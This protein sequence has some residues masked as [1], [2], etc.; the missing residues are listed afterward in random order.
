MVQDRTRHGP[1]RCEFCVLSHHTVP[2]T[3]IVYRSRCASFSTRTLCY[4]TAGDS[5]SSAMSS[6]DTRKSWRAVYGILDSE[7][8]WQS[9][10]PSDVSMHCSAPRARYALGFLLPSRP[11]S[12]LRCYQACPSHEVIRFFPFAAALCKSCFE[13]KSVT[14]PCRDSHTLTLDPSTNL[15][16]QCDQYRLSSSS[17]SMGRSPC[18]RGVYVYCRQRYGPLWSLR[19]LRLTVATLP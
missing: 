3:N 17:R 1:R 8:R 10:V 11:F 19:I 18:H 14:C 9:S 12:H 16:L 2:L 15:S 7:E 6:R 4:A 13:L 5:A